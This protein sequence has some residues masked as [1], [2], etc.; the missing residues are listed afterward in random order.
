MQ[1]PCNEEGFLSK[2]PEEPGVYKYYNSSGS[3]LYVGKAKNLKKRIASYFHKQHPDNK[4][5]VLVKQIS[6]I[7]TLLVDSEL[8]AL[9][10]ENNLIKENKPR[11]NILLKDD[12]TYPWLCLTKEP[13]PRIYSTRNRNNGQAE[14]YGPF[15]KGNVHKNLLTLIHELYPIRT[16]ALDLTERNIA[17]QRFS[18]CLEYHLKRC[19]GPCINFSLMASYQKNIAE[20]RYLLKGKTYSLIQQFRKEM[21]AAAHALEFEKAHALKS[22]IET[23][24]AFH[25]KSAMVNDLTMHCDVLTCKLVGEKLYYNYCWVREGRIDL[26]ISDKIVLPQDEALEELTMVLWHE[27]KLRFN[28]DETTILTNVPINSSIEGYRF[29][30]PLRGDK[31]KVLEFSMKNLHFVEFLPAKTNLIDF[32][33]RMSNLQFMLSLK[34]APTYIECFDNSNIQGAFP[35][36]ACVV[37][38]S[39]RPSNKDY[40]HFNVKTVEGPDDFAS[41]REIVTRRYQ[42]LLKEEKPL[43]TLIVIDGGKGQLSSAVEALDALELTGKIPIIGLAKRLEEIYLPGT[44]D[45]LVFDHSNPGLML[46]QHVRNEAHRF[47]ISHHRNQRSASFII[48]EFQN[49]PGVGAK[50]L[51]KIREHYPTMN[52]FKKDTPANQVEK[53]GARL[54]E[55]LRKYLTTV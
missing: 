36:A 19:E 33:A 30:T 38:K 14:Y 43:P 28:S 3:L 50:S 34:E 54:T 32:E 41:M 42:R 29:Y 22:K 20:I 46:L 31:V 1:I 17:S 16:C 18:V 23:L 4:T 44:S 51:E 8:D 35:V 27:L 11:Y 6:F 7:E 24:N 52:A 53:L 9:L 45:P 13:F 10:L 47:G 40:R 2:I 12:K 37:F 39:G 55:T 25:S 26:S 49:I 48:T 15:P 21:D 5:K